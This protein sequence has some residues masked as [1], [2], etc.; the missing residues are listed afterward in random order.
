MNTFDNTWGLPRDLI[1]WGPTIDSAR[2]RGSGECVRFCP[3]NVFEFDAPTG[4]ARVA[5]FHQC[6]VLCSHC[7]AVCPNG[8]ISFPEPDSFLDRVQEL[9]RQR[10]NPTNLQSNP[11]PVIP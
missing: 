5:R 3:N 7:V 4:Q 8:A 10:A 1:P 6:T 2:C 11:P 9:R